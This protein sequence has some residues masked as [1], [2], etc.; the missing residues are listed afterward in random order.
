M[1][2]PTAVGVVQFVGSGNLSAI[3]I[4]IS[5]VSALGPTFS[6]D[7]S[8]RPKTAKRVPVPLRGGVRPFTIEDETDGCRHEKRT[9]LSTIDDE[10]FVST[11]FH[12]MW[13]FGFT[14]NTSSA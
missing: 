1:P 10:T 4:R 11:N 2:N 12:L 3:V 6:E 8:N 13:P 14:Q 9:V 5:A 7:D